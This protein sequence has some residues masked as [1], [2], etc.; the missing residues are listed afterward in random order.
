MA[1]PSLDSRPCERV[2]FHCFN[3]E[4]IWSGHSCFT[5]RG[6]ETTLVIDPCAPPLGCAQRWGS[7]QAVLISHEHAGHSNIE[8]FARSGCDPRVFTGPG[9]YEVGGAFITGVPTYHDSENGSEKG[10]NTAYSIE[11]EGLRICH[12]GDLGHPLPAAAV[13]ELGHA[14]VLCVPVGDVST[15][16]VSEARTVAKALQPRY[17]LPMHYRSEARPELEPVDTFLAAMGVQQ[18][19]TRQKLNV[20]STNLPL[21]PQV[22]VLGCESRAG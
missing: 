11:M 14:D 10:R 7:P 9:E 15:L 1:E 12:L 6:K 21:N 20:T 4:I 19:E 17:I 3:M 18:A 13:R 5:L 2:S 8:G 22:L 16:S